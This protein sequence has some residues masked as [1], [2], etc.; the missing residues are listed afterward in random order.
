MKAQEHAPAPS[1]SSKEIEKLLK[2]D[3]QAMTPKQKTCLLDEI[4]ARKIAHAQEEDDV[5]TIIKEH[6][7]EVSLLWGG[8]CIDDVP[9][10]YGV[11]RKLTA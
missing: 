1:S 7:Q 9:E 8:Q 4:L 11:G 3:S 10:G 6:N 2:N 5:D